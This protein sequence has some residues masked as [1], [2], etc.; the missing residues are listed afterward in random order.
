MYFSLHIYVL[1][2]KYEMMAGIYPPTVSCC[3]IN[4]TTVGPTCNMSV[5]ICPDPRKY[6]LWD[7]VHP[8]E[9]VY[10]YMSKYLIK[11]VLP[12]FNTTA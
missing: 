10:R 6:F 12:Q 1:I 5:P 9:V 7:S 2:L 3:G 4:I 11:N 8:S